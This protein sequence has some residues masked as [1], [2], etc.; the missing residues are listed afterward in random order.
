MSI[1]IKIRANGCKNKEESP[2]NIN[3]PR[4]RAFFFE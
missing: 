1:N 4:R 3:K 2:N